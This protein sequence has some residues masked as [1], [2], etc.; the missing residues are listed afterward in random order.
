MLLIGLA[1][2]LGLPGLVSFW[3]EFLALYAAWSPAAD[4]P[5]TLM[6][7][8]VVLGAA[9]LALAAAYSLRV[10]RLVWSGEAAAACRRGAAPRSRR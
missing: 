4:R 5:V 6:R 3:G 9:G 10:A 2:A 8:C 7:V 1:A